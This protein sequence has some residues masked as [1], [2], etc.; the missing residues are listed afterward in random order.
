MQSKTK[1]VIIGFLRL[2]AAIPAASTA[3]AADNNT[4]AEDVA[5]LYENASTPET[6]SWLRGVDPDLDGVLELSSRTGTYVIGGGGT[7]PS[8]ALLTGLLVLGFGI[9]AVA[10]SNIGPVA[11]GTLAVGG[12]FAAVSVGIAPTWLSG[13][14][15]FGIGLIV[16]SVAKRLIN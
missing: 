1:T 2:I 11:G 15:M 13:V 6:D 14:L 5:P 16:A 3:V 4:T 7:G 10:R 9:G 8:G 12:T